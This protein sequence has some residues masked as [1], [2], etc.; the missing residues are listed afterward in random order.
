VAYLT[1]PWCLTPQ[2][3][4]DEASGYRCFT[5]SAEIAFVTC[6]SC[7]FVQTVS[8]RWT[9]YTCGRCQ[10]VGEL[11]R[12]WGYEAGSIAAKVQGTGQSWP[13]L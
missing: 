8:K 11:P 7:G 1:C 6:S 13:K 10:A 3:V 2:L 9:R 4:A 5:C 12:R